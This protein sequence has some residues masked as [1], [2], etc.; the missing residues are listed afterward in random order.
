[1]QASYQKRDLG[2]K[3]APKGA[4]T[5]IKSPIWT[6]FGGHFLQIVLFFMQKGA[7]L[8]QVALFLQFWVALSALADGLTCDPST[9]AQSE[10][11][12]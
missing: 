6:R 11:T 8:K 12:F 5:K 1:M 7:Y 9:P 10:H 2:A 4:T 3:G